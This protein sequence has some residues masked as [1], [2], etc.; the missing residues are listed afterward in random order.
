MKH[1]VTKVADS[2]V[3]ILVEADKDTWQNAQNKAFHRLASKVTIQGFRPGKAP[4]AM[5]RARVGEGQIINEALESVLTPFYSEVLAIEK[6]TPIN[7]PEVEV[8]EISNEKL[9]LKYRVTLYPTVTLGKYKD[10]HADKEAPSV[11][12][13]EVASSI[14]TRLKN[15]A[16]LVKV[17][18]P[19]A[20]GDTVVLDFEGFVDDKPFEGGKAENYELEL[21]SNSFIPGFEDQLV[22]LKAEES[23]DVNVTFPEQYVAEL[24]GKA[25][26]FVCK[27][28]EVKAKI[29]PDLTDEAVKDM[30]IKD[31]ETV[32]ALKEYE[33]KNLL[34]QKVS[35]AE[36]DYFEAIIKQIIDASS[37]EI[38]PQIL[39][40]EAANQEEQLRKQIESNGLTFAQYLEIT[41]QKEEDIKKQTA[42]QSKAAL[43]RYL[44]LNELAAKEGLLATDEEV[45]AELTKMAEQYKMKVEDIKKALAGQLE[46]FRDSIQQKKL[47][48]FL[49]ANNH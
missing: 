6:L 45:D 16:D 17:D 26:K 11:T 14:Q 42:D 48:E 15:A 36:A 41:G 35:K 24:A 25:A 22:G 19:A 38:A 23:K 43:I 21:G 1:T 31:V 18:R 5:L 30:A 44:V 27:V 10:L 37:V 20:L 46:Q 32:D 9:T 13:E 4:E 3:E 40:T 33:K 47:R 2:S 49:L 12:D 28:H 8:V 7:R 29:I 34:A 39:A